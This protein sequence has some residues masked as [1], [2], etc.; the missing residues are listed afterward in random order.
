MTVQ[1]NDRMFPGLTRYDAEICAR[2]GVARVLGQSRGRLSANLRSFS[3]HEA[4]TNNWAHGVVVSHPLRMR[5]ALGSNPSVSIR[6]Y[7]RGE[8]AGQ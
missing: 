5:K 2:K 3:I 6:I 4:T 1:S 7:V 8:L